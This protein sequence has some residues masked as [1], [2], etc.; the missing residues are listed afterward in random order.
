MKGSLKAN[1]LMIKSFCLCSELVS[2]GRFCSFESPW[3]FIFSIK[4][5]KIPEPWLTGE[6]THMYLSAEIQA[7][8]R[9]TM[10]LSQD[11]EP[12]KCWEQPSKNTESKSI[13]RD[14]F[15]HMIFSR[16]TFHP[17]CESLFST[18]DSDR[19][20]L[21]LRN[22]LAKCWSLLGLDIVYSPHL[23][24]NNTSAIKT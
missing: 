9:G 16:H 4:W 23:I 15:I 17:S 3:Y 13:N 12:N 7:T 24:I 11:Q 10:L 6:P 2:R 5:R 14:S 20:D 21:S 18:N 22:N 19:K 1:V 8:L